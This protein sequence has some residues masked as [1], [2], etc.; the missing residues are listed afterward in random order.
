MEI[1]QFSYKKYVPIKVIMIVI[2]DLNGIML[3]GFVLR[4]TIV[5]YEY[6]NSLLLQ[7][8]TN[9]VHRK[10]PEKWTAGFIMMLILHVTHCTSLVWNFYPV[11]THSL[12]SCTLFSE[13]APVKLLVLSK[14]SKSPW[15]INIMNQVRTLR[16]L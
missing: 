10:W 14:K 15:K 2:F 6:C 5:K 8:V 11:K 3:V 7:Y 12:S 13:S 1:T 9:S 16:H 4:N